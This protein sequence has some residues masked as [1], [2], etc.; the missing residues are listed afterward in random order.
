MIRYTVKLHKSFPGLNFT[1]LIDYPCKY[2]SYQQPVTWAFVISIFQGTLLLS[3]FILDVNS[4]VSKLKVY[5]TRCEVSE[6][7]FLIS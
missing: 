1:I 2:F 5:H 6:I 3:S 7:V 4:I